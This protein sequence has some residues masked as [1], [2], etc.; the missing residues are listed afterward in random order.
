MG[1]LF[2]CTSRYTQRTDWQGLQK[3]DFGQYC[4][5]AFISS[6]WRIAGIGHRVLGLIIVVIVVLLLSG[7]GWRLGWRQ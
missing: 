1:R 4:D 3:M 5:R 6:V 2:F 7:S